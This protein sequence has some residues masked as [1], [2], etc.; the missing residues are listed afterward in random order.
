MSWVAGVDEA[1]RG[2]VLGPMIVAAVALPRR[3]LGILEDLGVN[4]SKKIA[5]SRRARIA[6]EIR[7]IPGI[8]IA[9]EI[10]TP[11]EIDQAVL[12]RAVTLNG[13]TLARMAAVIDSVEPDEAYLDLVGRSPSKQNHRISQMLAK[14]VRLTACAKADELHKIAGAASIIAKVLRDEMIEEI[15]ELYAHYGPA[16]S[17]YPSDPQTAAFLAV[18]AHEKEIVRQSWNCAAL[19]RLNRR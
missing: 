18:A 10:A 5:S 12:D 11:E 7:K 8:R 15:G 19:R 6:V 4:D 14:P 16:G 3:K 17:G 1:G 9:V 2:P 13:L